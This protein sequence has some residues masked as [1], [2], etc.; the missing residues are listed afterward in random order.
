MCTNGDVDVHS[1]PNDSLSLTEACR[2]EVL[3]KLFVIDGT[4]PNTM[5]VFAD[6]VTVNGLALFILIDPDT[7]PVALLVERVS[8]TVFDI[9]PVSPVLIH[10]YAV[11]I[12]VPAPDIH[13]YVIEEGIVEVS[14]NWLNHIDAESEANPFI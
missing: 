4:M 8:N 2:V 3:T 11:P 14:P 12:S 7:D 1:F 6:D 13:L 5:L 10:E 9:V